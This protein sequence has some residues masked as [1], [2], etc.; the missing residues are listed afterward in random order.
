L[1][2]A[3]RD[4]TVDQRDLVG[5][6]LWRRAVRKEQPIG[7]MKRVLKRMRLI[8]I[9]SGNAGPLGQL[10]CVGAP[11][12]HDDID[13][14]GSKQAGQRRADAPR[15]T[16]YGNARFARCRLDFHGHVEVILVSWNDQSNINGTIVPRCQGRYL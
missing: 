12:Q 13:R 16:R 2:D 10:N 15:R 6:L 5:H 4:G 11:G 3:G 14:I 7:A 8:E 9:N 1:A